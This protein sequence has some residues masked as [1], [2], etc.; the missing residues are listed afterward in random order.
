MKEKG[1]NHPL[2]RMPRA[3]SEKRK[4]MDPCTSPRLRCNSN[5]KIRTISRVCRLCKKMRMKKLLHEL[6]DCTAKQGGERDTCTNLQTVQEEG[7]KRHTCMC[8]Q[9]LQLQRTKKGCLHT[10]RWARDIFILGKA[11][12]RSFTK[13]LASLCHFCINMMA[14]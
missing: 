6:L 7:S 5:G 1:K 13:H 14:Q 4:K 12:G 8:L 2:A 3:C 10:S 11:V 9:T